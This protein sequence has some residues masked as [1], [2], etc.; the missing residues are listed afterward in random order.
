[1][2]Y[3]ELSIQHHEVDLRRRD[4]LVFLM[5]NRFGIKDFVIVFLLL[6][7]VATLWLSMIQRDRQ[8]PVLQSIAEQ[9]RNLDSRLAGLE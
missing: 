4:S 2:H 7:I 5:Q 3:G 9:G 1:M 8:W 6:L